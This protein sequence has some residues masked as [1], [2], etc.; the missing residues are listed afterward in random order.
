MD[1]VSVSDHIVCHSIDNLKVTTF[2]LSFYRRPYA[3]YVLARSETS[4]S[5]IIF[6]FASNPSRVAALRS[7]NMEDHYRES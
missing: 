1:F 4:L 3:G 6:T 7:A 5:T 2:L